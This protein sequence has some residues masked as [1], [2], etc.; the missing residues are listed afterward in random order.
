MKYLTADFR[1]ADREGLSFLGTL[2]SKQNVDEYQN[3]TKKLI[4]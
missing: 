4:S 2:D 1:K 3:R